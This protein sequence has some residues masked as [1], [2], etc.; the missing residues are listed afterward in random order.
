ME[1]KIEYQRNL[2]KSYMILREIERA[3]C[4]ED[5]VL[6]QNRIGGLLPLSCSYRDGKKEYWYETTGRQSLDMYAD[7]CRIDE[8]LV[9]NLITGICQ[10]IEVTEKYLLD[11]NH[12]VLN[13]ESTFIRLP[14][15][16]YCFC[17][18]P[19]YQ[20]ELTIQL[21]HLSEYLLTKVDHKKDLAVKL[22]YELYELTL[23]ET[24]EAGDIKKMLIENRK[25]ILQQEEKFASN[26]YHEAEFDDTIKEAES[27]RCSDKIDKITQNPIEK[28]RREI[29]EYVVN[30]KQLLTPKQKQERN[31]ISIP[32]KFA[33]KREEI[34][35]Y[36]FE[37]EE[38]DLMTSHP[39]VLLTETKTKTQGI[40]A[41][42]GGKS[43][44]SIQINKTPFLIGSDENMV[45]GV[46]KSHAVSHRHA[47]I[48]EESG[49]FFIEDLNSTNGT[50]VGGLDL[51][52]KV[53]MSLETN[54]QIIF[55]DEPYRFL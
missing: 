53:K 12:I 30:L 50:K 5:K 26:H 27:D 44:S 2:N 34:K 42:E 8:E 3:D 4:F 39:T 54:E 16:E 20:E 47:R 23:Q 52:Y 24:F 17:Y 21:R 11:S 46:I 38:E 18:C 45:D 40:L 43:Q 41:Y 15:K 55:A 37:P 13:I 29:Q 7:I 6:M 10:V 33:R 22:V 28:F 49:V 36:V 19:S 31:L 9:L 25:P 1:M 14:E 35:P 51:N 32:V 48:T